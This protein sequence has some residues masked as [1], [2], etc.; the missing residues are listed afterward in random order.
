[1]F[2]DPNENLIDMLNIML[3]D[4]DNEHINKLLKYNTINLNEM[5]K[6]YLKG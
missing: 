2:N 5:D 4:V 6:Q 1:M 3:V